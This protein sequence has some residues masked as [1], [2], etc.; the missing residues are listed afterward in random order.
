MNLGTLSHQTQI[1]LNVHRIQN[2]TADGE[3]EMIE[4]APG[5]RQ[6]LHL[7]SNQIVPMPAI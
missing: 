7:A 2:Q 3:D 6:N 4:R 1:E 5:F